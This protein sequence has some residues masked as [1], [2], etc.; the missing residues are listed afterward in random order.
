VNRVAER[1]EDLT[2]EWLSGAFGVEVRSATAQAIGAGQTGASYRIDL[3]TDG[4]P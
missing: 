3:D 1:V 2:P 4:G